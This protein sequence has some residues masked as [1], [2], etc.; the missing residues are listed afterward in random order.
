MKKILYTV[1]LL[2]TMAGFSGCDKG[3]EK[4]N[5]DPIRI[6]SASPD[7]LLAPALVNTLRTN[8]LRNRNFNNELMQVTVTKSDAEFAI[9]R[10]DFRPTYADNTWN[11]WYSELT[12]FKDIYEV[13]SMPEYQNNSYKGISLVCEAWVTQ[14]ITDTYGDVPHTEAN[15]GK[16]GLV[17]PAFDAQKDI[18]TSL[19]GKLEEANTLFADN[20]AIKPES[21]PI[22]HGDVALWRKFGNSLYL[23]LLLRASGKTA[24]IAGGKTAVQKIA[25][26]VASPSTYPIF[27]SNAESAVLKWTGDV[28]SDNPYTSPF[29]TALRDIDFTLPSMCNFFMLK[30]SGWHDPRIEIATPYGNGSRNRLGIAPGNGGFV[31]IDS[32]Y[33]PGADEDKQAYFYAYTTSDFSLHKNPLTGILM[34]YAEVQFILAEAAAKG[35]ITGSAE[36]YYYTGIANAINYWVPNFSTN[37]TGAEFTNYIAYA[38][39]GWDNSL[40]LDA[41][42]SDSKMERIHIQK[43]YSLFLTD[44]QQWFEYR[45]TGHPILPKGDGLKNGKKMPARLNYPLYVQS[46]NPTNYTKAVA[47]MGGDDINTLVWWQKP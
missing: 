30:L 36:T 29:V 2:S 19:L 1:A 25:D 35:W 16:Y 38:G 40:P 23:R 47:G 5:T 22:Y 21:D 34:T 13:A 45:R 31:G 11:A 39:I 18:Y 10:Y 6:I 26:M 44:F 15:K 3:F 41:A 14:M 17:E 27:M 4:E 43:Y 32:G 8:M 46:A 28:A 9:F 20:V 37:I 42:T 12:N 33:E 24:T 7:K